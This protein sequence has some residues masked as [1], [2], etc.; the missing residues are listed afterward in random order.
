MVDEALVKEARGMGKRSLIVMTS[1]L[2]DARSG[3][4]ITTYRP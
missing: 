4:P 2:I 1:A 3:F